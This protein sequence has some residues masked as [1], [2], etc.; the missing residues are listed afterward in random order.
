LGNLLIREK[1]PDP[2]SIFVEIFLLI[3]LMKI[4][5]M[6]SWRKREM[7]NSRITISVTPIADH[8]SILRINLM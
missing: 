4:F 6:L 1:V 7:Q 5:T 3:D 8:L 2:N